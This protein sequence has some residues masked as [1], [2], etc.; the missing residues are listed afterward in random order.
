M[1]F[2]NRSLRLK[3]NNEWFRFLLQLADLRNLYDKIP[4]NACKIIRYSGPM[5]RLTF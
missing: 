3:L 1:I 4:P 5:M 2:R